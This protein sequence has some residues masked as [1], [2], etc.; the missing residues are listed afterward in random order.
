MLAAAAAFAMLPPVAQLLLA[1][2][3]QIDNRLVRSAMWFVGFAGLGF[4]AL[5]AAFAVRP[6]LA[7]GIGAWLRRRWTLLA[8]SAVAL[9]AAA[10]AAFFIYAQHR[11]SVDLLAR[12]DPDSP[13]AAEVR[14]LNSEQG[15]NAALNRLAQHFISRPHRPLLLPVEL[16]GLTK[17]QSEQLAEQVVRGEIGRATA[18]TD[19]AWKPGDGIRWSAPTPQGVLWQLQRQVF[20][21]NLLREPADEDLRPRVHF[22]QSYV[23]TWRRGNPVWPN[24]NPYAWNDD[25]TSN[26]IQAHILLMQRARQAGVAS[27]EQELAFL[28]SLVQ[29]GDRLASPSE[30]NRKT[31]HGL[32]QNCA[33]L[34]ISAHYPEL[35]AGGRWRAIAI[36]RMTDQLSRTVSPDGEFLE[37]SP[38]YQ[39]YATCWVMWFVTTAREAGIQLPDSHEKAARGMLAFCRELL[40]PDRSLPG[41]GDTKIAPR[42]LSGWPWQRL[43]DWPEVAALRRA[44]AP[45]GQM[46][47]EPAARLWPRSGYFLLRAAAPRWDEQGGMFLAMRTG[48][49]TKAHEYHD[50]LS[51]T[52]FGNGRPLITGADYPGYFNMDLRHRSVATRSQNTVSVDGRSQRLGEAPVLFSR[53][54]SDDSGQPLFAA[55]SAESRLYDDAVHRRTL[56]YGPRA[57]AVLLIDE[58]LAD[59]PHD[60]RQH[61]RLN[62]QFAFTLHDGRIV[63]TAAGRPMLTMT[64]TV[65]NE[66]KANRP[67]ATSA[68]P[69]VQFETRDANATFV[70]VLDVSADQSEAGLQVNSDAIQWR[71]DR[72]SVTV[73]LP[74]RSTDDVLWQGPAGGRSPASQADNP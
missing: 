66:G 21:M 39:I 23:E 44:A 18:T 34:A 40:Q 32:M 65:L 5:L 71:G 33:L 68:D 60:Y 8:G 20:L 49:Q 16:W 63:A 59:E 7:R 6:G 36:D 51:M 9:A 17:R 46:P 70:T 28:R 42:D 74:V 48:P 55:V 50:A 10:M 72:G 73:R 13:I 14:R 52:L 29:H 1:R 43:G 69:M 22:A 56:I 4:A 24:V 54:E 11:N 38:G 64:S 61:F 2:D 12:L 19:Y 62:P 53:V 47:N 57:G 15:A 45:T 67:S 27:A 25:A 35:D 58:L 31:N 26:R 3:G 41:I 37:I 30:Y